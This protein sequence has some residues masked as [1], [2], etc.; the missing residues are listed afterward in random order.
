[1][2]KIMYLLSI[3]LMVVLVGCG[4]TATTKESVATDVIVDANQ[5]SRI[6]PEKLFSIMGS[7]SSTDKWNYKSLNGTTYDAITYTFDKKV[8]YEFLVIDN[9]VVR[10]TFNSEK[11]N[12]SNGKSIKFNDQNDLLLMFGI[13]P[14]NDIK[15]IADTGSSLRYQL[16]SDKITEFWVVDIDKENKSFDTVKITYN[17][18]YF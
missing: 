6:T 16:V 13:T 5:F 2:K 10:F 17:L 18:N 12:D 9:S 14:S 15:K 11:Y 3:V 7:P 8:C 1:M 4:S